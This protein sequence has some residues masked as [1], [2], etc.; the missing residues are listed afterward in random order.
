MKPSVPKAMVPPLW[1]PAFLPNE[2]I[3]RRDPASTSVGLPA[4][5]CHSETTF[6]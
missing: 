6:L 3:S 5:M 4:L 1:L 2:M